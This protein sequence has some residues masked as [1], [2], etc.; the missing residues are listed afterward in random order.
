M[1]EGRATH[2][3]HFDGQSRVWDMR[4]QKDWHP[5]PGAGQAGDSWPLEDTLST[6]TCPILQQ[7]HHNFKSKP[8]RTLA[9]IQSSLSQRT[10]AFPC[11]NV[12]PKCWTHRPRQHPLLPAISPLWNPL[13]IK[14]LARGSSTYWSL[15]CG[16]GH[17]CESE[18]IRGNR[19]V[20]V[21]NKLNAHNRNR[22]LVLH[23]NNT[24]TRENICYH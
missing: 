13:Y 10:G 2:L 5:L 12:I 22:Q 11:K 1:R 24:F 17:G 19:W 14:P 9:I 15:G 4:W 8:L 6:G 16:R 20:S 23:K 21:G 7:Q 3:V 18:R